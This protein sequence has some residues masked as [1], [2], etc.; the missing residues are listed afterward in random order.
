MR[1]ELR[2]VLMAGNLAEEQKYKVGWA[3][4][5][6]NG[7]VVALKKSYGSESLYSEKTALTPLSTLTTVPYRAE[8]LVLSGFAGGGGI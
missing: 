7:K 3:Y 1:T 6:N 4:L 5:P 8:T 2:G